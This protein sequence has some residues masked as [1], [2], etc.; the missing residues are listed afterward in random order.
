MIT[1]LKENSGTFYQVIN[2]KCKIRKNLGLLHSTQVLEWSQAF[3]RL[4]SIYPTPIREGTTHQ[5]SVTT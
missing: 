1:T 5:E 4:S 3:S 2:S